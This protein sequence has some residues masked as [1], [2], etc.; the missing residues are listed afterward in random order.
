MIKHHHYLFIN[1]T[2]TT[3][4]TFIIIIIIGHFWSRAKKKQPSQRIDKYMNSNF[5]VKE[6][7]KKIFA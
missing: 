1:E 3:M 7:E 4:T 5:K 6:E 2:T